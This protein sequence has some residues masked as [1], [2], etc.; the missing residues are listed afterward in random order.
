LGI[1]PFTGCEDEIL[2]PVAILFAAGVW[3]N[4]AADRFCVEE[5]TGSWDPF[6]GGDDCFTGAVVED[7]IVS[8]STR[9]F[10][11]P[12]SMWSLMNEFL[13]CL[14]QIGQTTILARMR[15]NGSDMGFSGMFLETRVGLK[16]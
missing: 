16:V 8:V 12:E 13:T 7:G 10:W 3:K 5:G 14:S 11:Q 6:G 9:N 1:V 2:P 4:A 15:A